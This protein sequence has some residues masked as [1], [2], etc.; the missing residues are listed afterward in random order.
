MYDSTMS[1]TEA[2]PM[3]WLSLSA[4]CLAAIAITVLFSPRIGLYDLSPAQKQIAA[5]LR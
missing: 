5:S 1:H 3:R 4:V 2:N